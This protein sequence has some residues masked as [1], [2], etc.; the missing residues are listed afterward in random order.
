MIV[1]IGIDMVELER[2]DKLLAGSA[3]SRFLERVLTESE[4]SRCRELSGRRAV[5]F[6]AGRYA[7]KEAIVKALGCGIGRLVGFADMEV[8]PDPSG[9]PCCRLSAE[10]WE[11]LGLKE[12][13]H[14]LHVA[15]THERSMAAATAVFERE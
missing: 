4:R 13:R 3:G 15:I 11:R 1:G 7:A 10:A 6:V 8:L 5:E 9:R 12:E 2:L 14:R